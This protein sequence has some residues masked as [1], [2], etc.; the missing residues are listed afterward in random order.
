LG[1]RIFLL[2]DGRTADLLEAIRQHQSGKGLRNGSEAN[3]VSNN[4]NGLSES[5]KQD[6]LNFLRS[7]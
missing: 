3:S 1:Q 7:L 2:H 6:L 4:F 5:E